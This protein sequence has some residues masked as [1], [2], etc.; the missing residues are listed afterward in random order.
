MGLLKEE[1]RSRPETVTSFLG[2]GPL[3][4]RA[5]CAN[6]ALL[7][8]LTQE[9]EGKELLPATPKRSKAHPAL[10]TAKRADHPQL[11]LPLE[12]KEPKKSSH[13]R[14][15]DEFDDL[16][17]DSKPEPAAKSAKTTSNGTAGK[18]HPSLHHQQQQQQQHQHQQHGQHSQQQQKERQHQ[19]HHLQGSSPHKLNASS[20]NPNSNT[21]ASS[22]PHASRKPSP[23][24]NGSQR[25]A[26]RATGTGPVPGRGGGGSS[27][28]GTGH[29]AGPRSSGGSAHNT[30]GK[31]P[32]H[33]AHKP[34]MQGRQSAPGR[35]QCA[36]HSG[37]SDG[38]S[39]GISEDDG[40]ESWRREMRAVTGYDPSRYAGEPADDRSM[41]V[42]WRQLQAE[43]KRSARTAR[44]EDDEAEKEEARHRAEKIKK[45]EARQKEKRKAGGGKA[46]ASRHPLF[47]D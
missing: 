26:G 47:M 18:L 39:E 24:V 8:R 9:K 4:T 1:R 31:Q 27:S 17:D 25:Q 19:P 38:D 13:K 40:D 11:Y 30:H 35:Q 20:S 34:V 2:G 6:P 43:E 22:H 12:P 21:H 33:G 15:L 29:L 28:N 16:N 10:G 42:G 23:A 37:E 46:G 36:G 32:Q 7:P 45:K 14:D 3:S 41:V 5:L 44:N